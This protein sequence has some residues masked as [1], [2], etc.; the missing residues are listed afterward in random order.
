MS[1][2]SF[3]NYLSRICSWD[4]NLLVVGRPKTLGD[5]LSLKTKMISEKI[6]AANKKGQ[7]CKAGPDHVHG[8]NESTK[9]CCKVTK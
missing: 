1:E 4:Y 6:K 8:I 7:L 9:V 5:L 2:K 3:G